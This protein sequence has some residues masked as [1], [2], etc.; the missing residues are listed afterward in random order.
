MR[1]EIRRDAAR[2]RA[3]VYAP[4]PTDTRFMYGI[5]AVSMLLVGMAVIG[6]FYGVDLWTSPW[7]IA[8]LVALAALVGLLVRRL[9]MRRHRTA[10][11]QE[12]DRQPGDARDDQQDV[13]TT[14]G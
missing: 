10:H 7:L 1:D 9:R 5:I 12:Y 13:R 4:R 11:R 8:L 14:Q 2:R 3:E 6:G